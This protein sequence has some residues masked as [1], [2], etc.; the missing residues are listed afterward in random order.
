MLLEHGA[1]PNVVNS[2]GH[3]PIVSA[4]HQGQAGS[5]AALAKHKK[6]NLCAQV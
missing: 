3:T 4:V 6:T 5:V 1:D 2:K